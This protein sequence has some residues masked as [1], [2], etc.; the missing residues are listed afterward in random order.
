M[1]SLLP[2]SE[3]LL[4]LYILLVSFVV[5]LMNIAHPRSWV[6]PQPEML[7]NATRPSPTLNASTLASRR[8]ANPKLRLPTPLQQLPSPRE[9]LERGHLRL[10]L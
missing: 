10:D 7:F 1:S 3:G 2:Q 6:S 5:F 8:P 4:P 9:H